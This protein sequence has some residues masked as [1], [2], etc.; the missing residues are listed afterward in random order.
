MN[1]KTRI[2]IIIIVL[3][4][5]FLFFNLHIVDRIKGRYCTIDNI[6]ILYEDGRYRGIWANIRIDKNG[7]IISSRSKIRKYDV[8]KEYL[9]KFIKLVNSKFF[10]T[11]SDFNDGGT[12]IEKSSITVTN[13]ETGYS[14]TIGGYGAF[15]NE[16]FNKYAILLDM[17]IGGEEVIR[18]FKR[19][20]EDIDTEVEKF[21]SNVEI[22]DVE[23]EYKFKR[24]KD[25]IPVLIKI[26]NN[27]YDILIDNK[28]VYS[29]DSEHISSLVIKSFRN[30]LRNIYFNYG[31]ETINS[32]DRLMVLRNTNNRKRVY[33]WR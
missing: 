16:E 23:I 8:D 18:S 10:K 4:I 19:D 6:E 31:L 28:M 15:Y 1:K 13:K 29:N 11:K 9:L 32:E 5:V 21:Y 17:A 3:I 26:K 22:K 33:F 14:Y 20:A 30:D 7:V 27:H 24:E 2:I 25:G 12:D